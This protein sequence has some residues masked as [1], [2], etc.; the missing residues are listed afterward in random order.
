VPDAAFAPNNAW[1]HQGFARS[2]AGSQTGG[3]GAGLPGFDGRQA[4]PARRGKH[5]EGPRPGAAS[6]PRAQPQPVGNWSVTPNALAAVQAWEQQL[7]L[8]SG[9]MGAGNVLPGL[10]R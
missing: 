7:Q 9:A 5:A 8:R 1:A 10:G 3:S 4:P 6:A 2:H